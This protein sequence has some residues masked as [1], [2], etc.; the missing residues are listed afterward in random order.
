MS[1][2]F[3]SEVRT[4]THRNK[5]LFRPAEIDLDG[6][7]KEMFTHRYTLEAYQP[8]FV[9]QEPGQIKIVIEVEPWN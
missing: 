7:L 9:P 3:R 5:G 2:G 8:A 6:I 4:G 1:C